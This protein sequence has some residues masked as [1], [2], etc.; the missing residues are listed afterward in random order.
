[1]LPNPTG[2]PFMSTRKHRPVEAVARVAV[3]FWE[4]GHVCAKEEG[5][6]P[7]KAT[8]LLRDGG[9]S[10]GTQHSTAQHSTA[11]CSTAQHSTRRSSTAAQRTARHGTAQHSHTQPPTQTHTLCNHGQ[12]Q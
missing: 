10:S 5:I 12:T 4:L 7:Q 11:Q 6:T 8:K 1:M 2:T 3:G 9:V